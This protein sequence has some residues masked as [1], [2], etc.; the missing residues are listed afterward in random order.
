MF[1]KITTNFKLIVCCLLSFAPVIEI[2]VVD[3]S[4][5]IS[6]SQHGSSC[7]GCYEKTVKSVEEIQYKN[8]YFSY[9]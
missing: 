5:R 2:Y 8:S 9:V 6:F 4:N 3:H 1:P 7:S